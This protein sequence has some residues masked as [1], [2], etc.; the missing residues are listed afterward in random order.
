MQRKKENNTNQK[1]CQK[2][3][4][5]QKKVAF[6]LQSHRINQTQKINYLERLSNEYAIRCIYLY[7]R[8]YI[9]N[10][11]LV[12]YLLTI[13]WVSEKPDLQFGGGIIC[14]T[15]LQKF[16]Y[17]R[18][19]CISW[20]RIRGFIPKPI[21][22]IWA[23]RGPNALKKCLYL[24]QIM[25]QQ[26]KDVRY[27]KFN[28]WVSD[29]HWYHN[30]IRHCVTCFSSVLFAVHISLRLGP[31][32][33]SADKQLVFMSN[34]TKAK[35]KYKAIVIKIPWATEVGKARV[36]EGGKGGRYQI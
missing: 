30:N 29:E 2:A 13:C 5:G 24:L 36:K 11:H 1:N 32:S 18:S 20:M 8:F 16:W 17:Y 35:L 4:T 12:T 31:K 25:I 21:H 10:F 3:S 22:I 33:W 34:K 19:I 28:F 27:S 15:R 6:I 7:P 14:W 23:E 26:N 9:N